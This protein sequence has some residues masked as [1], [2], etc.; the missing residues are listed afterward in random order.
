MASSSAFHSGSK[1]RYCE[2]CEQT[3]REYQYYQLLHGLKHRKRLEKRQRTPKGKGIEIPCGT[4]LVIEQEAL[5]KDA[6]LQY[7]YSL[8]QRAA[9]RSCL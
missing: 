7:V 8:C 4:A 6:V 2:V 9:L 5:Y 3:F 1:D